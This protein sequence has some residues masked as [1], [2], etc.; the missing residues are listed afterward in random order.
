MPKK[1]RIIKLTICCPG[2]VEREIV[3]IREEAESWNRL[4]QDSENLRIEVSHWSTD[5]APTMEERAQAA[6]NRKI[7]DDADIIVAVLWKRLGT[8]TGL[9]N[10]GTEEE[11][12]RA[13]ARGIRVLPYFSNLESPFAPTDHDQL[14]KLEAFK[15][16]MKSTGFSSSYNSRRDF[17]K[18]FA[19]HIDIAVREVS[20]KRTAKK[21]VPKKKNISQKAKGDG[22][23]QSAG[24]NNIFNI[25]TPAKP[26][27]FVERN[28]DHITPAQQKQVTDWIHGLADVSSG[29]DIGELR[30]E[31]W[32]R[33][34]NRF[35][36]P[37]YDLLHKDQLP[38]VK[39]WYKQQ[40]AILKQEL[41]VTAPDLW[42]RSTIGS[43]KVMMRKLGIGE[44]G[45]LDYYEKIS[46]RLNMKRPFK[47]LKKL[48]KTDLKRVYGAVSRDYNKK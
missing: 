7:I 46:D 35:K 34:H 12:T 44:E 18:L 26:S 28:P 16:R 21:K 17:R 22:N 36:V 10:S 43:I 3:I 9:A 33:L 37:R 11:I 30:A 29:K 45:K 5:C 23:I 32:S 13:I 15:A 47:S 14:A 31:W 19:G 38:A 40:L 20:E 48:S 6:I 41:S 24:D 8:P 39:M 4:Y 1:V 27:I 2:D 25:K 42:R